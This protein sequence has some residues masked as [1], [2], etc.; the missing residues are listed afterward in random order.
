[1]I[2]IFYIT[3]ISEGECFVEKEEK[4]W[5]YLK[6]KVL[7]LVIVTMLPG[8][9]NEKSKGRK[10]KSKIPPSEIIKCFFNFWMSNRKRL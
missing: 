9:T 8:C 10:R 1:M 6:K 5:A 3:I 2:K 7:K 4:I